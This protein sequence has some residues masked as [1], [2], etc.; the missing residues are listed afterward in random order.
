[1]YGSSPET[2][3]ELWNLTKNKK[4]AALPNEGY[5]STAVFTKVGRVYAAGKELVEWDLFANR[6]ERRIAL[7]PKST[8][9]YL[10]ISADERGLLTWG[11]GEARSWSTVTGEQL[12]RMALDPHDNALALSADGKQF[13]VAGAQSPGARLRDT[14][15]GN[16]VQ[17]LGEKP[18]NA[19]AFSPDGRLIAVGEGSGVFQLWDLKT[20]KRLRRLEGHR[21]IVKT[22]LF[23]PDSHYLASVSIDT[24]V[25]VWDVRKIAPRGK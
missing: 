24:T 10:L 25:L 18:V 9:P 8:H 1:M 6:I 7:P 23:S 2:G 11:D 12:S 20:R 21:G 22:L 13:V 5:T 19:S 3:I 15:S 14:R 17:D 4:T 16:V